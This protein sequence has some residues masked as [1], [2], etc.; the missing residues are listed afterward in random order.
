[1]L[2]KCTAPIRIFDLGGWT[3]P[4]FCRRRQGIKPRVFPVPGGFCPNPQTSRG[5]LGV[6]VHVEND[7]DHSH[8][9][10][11]GIAG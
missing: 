5:Q 3:D 9:S 10:V 11:F 1:M 8:V 4:W 2:V 6:M 7:Q